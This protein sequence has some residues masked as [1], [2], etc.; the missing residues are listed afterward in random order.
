MTTLLD[1]IPVAT[2][3]ELGK[4]EGDTAPGHQ[5]D[6]RSPN[7]EEVADAALDLLGGD[8]HQFRRLFGHAPPLTERANTIWK[9]AWTKAHGAPSY[10]PSNR[11]SYTCPN[12]PA[13]GAQKQSAPGF[14]PCG[15]PVPTIPGGR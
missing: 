12:H 2:Q 13:E 10:Q 8:R 11:P 4:I 14:L 5:H 9:D 3:E 6:T 7:L 15:C 1:E